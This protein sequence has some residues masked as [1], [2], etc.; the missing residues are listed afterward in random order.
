M[1]EI[2]PNLQPQTAPAATQPNP[3]DAVMPPV[4]QAPKIS[5]FGYIFW[6]LMIPPVTTF[7]AMYFAWKKSALHRLM[8][9]MTIVYTVLFGLWSLLM[10]SA[11]GAFSSYFSQEVMPVP[12]FDKVV[13]VVLIILG[14]GGG[15]YFRM[16]VKREQKLSFLWVGFLTAILVLQVFAGFHQLTFISG[17]VT[18]AQDTVLGL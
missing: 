2:A 6:S 3:I 10:F 14:I 9:D 4:A 1:N 11:P 7:L 12:T 18:Q 17:V 8:P 15:F 16:K 5:V 13:A